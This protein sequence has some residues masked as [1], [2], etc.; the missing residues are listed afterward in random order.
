MCCGHPND[1]PLLRA[2]LSNPVGPPQE[3]ERKKRELATENLRRIIEK[4][5]EAV[6][7]D[8]KRA[9]AQAKRA[10][11]QG[12]DVNSMVRS[13]ETFRND[14]A[15]KDCAIMQGQ[16]GYS[17]IYLAIK[18]R[19]YEM[20]EILLSDEHIRI[21]IEVSFLLLLCIR[22]KSNHAFLFAARNHC[23]T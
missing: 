13:C 18:K 22:M 7:E 23:A 5:K 20:A 3:K 21:C 8:A 4:G 14:N 10:I 1:H 9:I 16:T 19:Y 12:A 17:N 2:S 15:L 6:P 11:A